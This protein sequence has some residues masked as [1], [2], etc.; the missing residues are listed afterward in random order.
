MDRDQFWNVI[1]RVKGS[2]RPEAA[3]AEELGKLAPEEI[4]SYQEHFDSLFAEANTWDLW[5]AAYLIEGGCSD[6]GFTD[7]RYG[8][9]SRGRQVFE[10]ALADP[11]SLAGVARPQQIS[12]EAFGY[13]AMKVYEEK[14]DSEMPR[15]TPA[16]SFEPKGE[17][18]DFEDLDEC[19]S[20][21]P[22]LTA[23]YG[24]PGDDSPGK[25]WWKFW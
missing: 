7:F 19:A 20:R 10:S 21:L 18:W 6:D 11:D 12:D 4:A 1:D 15:D 17:E 3:I 9:I 22:A 5:G 25:P 16:D 2:P 23:K 14:T 13:A 8:L 24:E